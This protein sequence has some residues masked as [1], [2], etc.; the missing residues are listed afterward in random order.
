MST[1]RWA[2]IPG[3]EGS[4]QVSDQGRVRSVDR[5]Q[6]AKNPRTNRRHTRTYRGKLL[7]SATTPCG[8]CV[9]LGRGSGTRYIHVLVA[10]AFIGPRP[11]KHD[12]CHANGDNT[13][14]RVENLRYGTRSEN[15][16]DMV[17][18]G[19]R[20]LPVSTVHE[21]RRRVAAG[22]RQADVG[23]ALGVKHGTVSDIINGRSYSCV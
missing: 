23:R 19:K 11:P 18:H 21:I 6:G 15:N 17:R 13:D 12:V 10:L 7:R 20:W 1:E 4:Y 2:D 14:N 22:E 8:E 9:V 16:E 5:V 3:Y